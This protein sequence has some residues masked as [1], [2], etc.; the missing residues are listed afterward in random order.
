M[1]DYIGRL[2]GGE[3]YEAALGG[4]AEHES[5]EEL[6]RLLGEV[7]AGVRA[8]R[9]GARSCGVDERGADRDQVADFGVG[10][11]G[12]GRELRGGALEAGGVTEH[13]RVAG[14]EPLQ[15]LA[16]DGRVVGT[17]RRR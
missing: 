6:G 2:L 17:R 7:E 14:H 4:R 5:A 9:L 3:G 12:H 10:R 15:L 16:Y 1:R 8:T 13:A 11:A